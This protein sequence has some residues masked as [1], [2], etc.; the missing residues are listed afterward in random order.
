MHVWTSFNK[1]ETTAVQQKILVSVFD[2]YASFQQENPG[3]ALVKNPP[4]YTSS[5]GLWNP[6]LES[7]SAIRKNAGS[8]SV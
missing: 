1:L 8:G 2:K 7:G 6:D 5:V 3:V 4:G